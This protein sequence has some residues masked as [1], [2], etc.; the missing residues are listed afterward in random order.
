MH[1]RDSLNLNLRLNTPRNQLLPTALCHVL[2]RLHVL[3]VGGHAHV[4]VLGFA[5]ELRHQAGSGPTV[6]VY[7]QLARVE[8]RLRGCGVNIARMNAVRRLLNVLHNII[9]AVGKGQRAGTDRTGINQKVILRGDGQVIPE[10]PMRDA[11]LLARCVGAQPLGYHRADVGKFRLGDDCN[12]VALLRLLKVVLV[13]LEAQLNIALPHL[14]QVL[15]A[16]EIS[17]SLHH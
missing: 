5:V 17:M 13:P 3:G 10:R 1:Y 15:F 8:D 4:D 7:R 11:Q 14:V 6:C 2:Q 12:L 9:N 16:E